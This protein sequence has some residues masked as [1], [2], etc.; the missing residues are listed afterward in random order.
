MKEIV[1]LSGK[2][3][4]GKTS[5]SASLAILAQQEAIIADC[6]VDAANLHILLEANFDESKIFY[7]GELA[8]IDQELCTKC[9]LCSEVCQFDAIPF[10]HGEYRVKMLSCEG[11]AYCEKVCP[12]KA[13]SMH[14]RKSGE[15]YIS[16]I[17]SN[18]KMVHAKLDIGADNS[19]K[20]VAEVK[21]RAKEIA[22]KENKK[23]VIVDGSP[24]I[25]CPVVSSLSGAN[26]VI[27]VTE[28][29]VSGLHDLER[30]HA[31]IKRFRTRSSCIINKYD[32]NEDMSQKIERFLESEDITL[33]SKV[34][35]DVNFAK[36]MSEAKTVVEYEIPIKQTIIDTWEKIKSEIN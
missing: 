3:G 15:L 14:K 23:Y 27:L 18:T 9:G 11:C 13:I 17:K 31:V 34:P 4:T 20:L 26:Y 12:S 25:G 16:E 5:I 6:D 29:T 1:V 28:P 21:N 33:L 8:E 30:L 10:H 22:K 24:G 35:Y 2:G 7:S 32:I 36:A 19:G